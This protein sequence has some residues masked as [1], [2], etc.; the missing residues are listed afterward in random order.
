MYTYVCMYIC[1]NM[2]ISVYICMYMYMYIC[3]FVHA[4]I[5]ILH[6]L[7]PAMN[8]VVEGICEG[9]LN[10]ITAAG[11]LRS[12]RAPPLHNSS[13]SHL[14]P[15]GASRVGPC[16]LSY[17]CLLHHGL[18]CSLLTSPCDKQFRSHKHT[19]FHSSRGETDCNQHQQ[20]ML[21]RAVADSVEYTHRKSNDEEARSMSRV[22]SAS[23]RAAERVQKFLCSTQRKNFARNRKF[24]KSRPDESNAQ[25]G[26]C[27]GHGG[28]GGDSF[29]AF[30][31]SAGAFAT[32]RH[33]W[34]GCWKWSTFLS[35]FEWID[36]QY[37]SFRSSTH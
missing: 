19:R 34:H 4:Y 16:G 30:R 8:R 29:L 11:A 1:I 31:C 9:I 20:C 3:I 26:A 35:L 37:T 36:F 18:T 32:G 6:S 24:S 25:N 10:R 13:E 33:G 21:I 14:D 28:V 5:F 2:Y 23:K 15:W 7:P 12:A 17:I 27:V 22:L